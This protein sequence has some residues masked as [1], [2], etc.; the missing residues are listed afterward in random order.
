MTMQL[1]LPNIIGTPT[2]KLFILINLIDKIY[3]MIEKF[4]NFPILTQLIAIYIVIINIVAF[5]YYG[6]D[7]IKSTINSRR[8]SEKMLFLVALLGGSAGAIAGMAYF[9]HKTKKV[10]FQAGLAIILAVQILLLVWFLK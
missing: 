8:I 3:N 2:F 10:S 9:R 4:L 7:K 6:I 5:F 1:F